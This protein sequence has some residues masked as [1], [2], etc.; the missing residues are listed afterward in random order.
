MLHGTE[1]NMFREK[2]KKIF[3]LVRLSQVDYSKKNSHFSPSLLARSL[4]QFFFSL[5]YLENKKLD[6]ER[7]KEEFLVSLYTDRC[8]DDVNV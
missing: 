4:Q 2:K 1:L 3:L 7:E 6:R 5:S 8:R